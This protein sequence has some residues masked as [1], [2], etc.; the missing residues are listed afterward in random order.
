MKIL[1]VGFGTV[2]KAQKQ[3]AEVLGHG[4]F[5]YDPPKFPNITLKRDA[6]IIFVCVPDSEVENMIKE[7]QRK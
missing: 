4:V 1:I 6:Q 5:V 2:G 7:L 3:L